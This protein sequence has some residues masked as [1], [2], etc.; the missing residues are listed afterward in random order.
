VSFNDR[1]WRSAGVAN[2]RKSKASGVFRKE[3]YKY[4][5]PGMIE[6]WQAKFLADFTRNLER[7]A[8]RAAPP[9]PS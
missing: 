7:N 6:K 9:K 5:L 4:S 3:P 1:P 2:Q 8:E